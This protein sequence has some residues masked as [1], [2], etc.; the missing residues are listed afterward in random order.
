M[1]TSPAVASLTVF[2]TRVLG[3]TSCGLNAALAAAGSGDWDF[4]NGD[5]ETGRSDADGDGHLFISRLANAAPAMPA[6]C[7]KQIA[8][9]FGLLDHD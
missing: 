2:T 5:Q 8:P 9:Q 6:T 1:D 3:F 7:R 4:R